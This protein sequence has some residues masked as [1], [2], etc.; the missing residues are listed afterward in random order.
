MYKSNNWI[1]SSEIKVKGKLHTR[2]L[3]IYVGYGDDRFFRLK[4]EDE[5]PRGNKAY[6]PQVD[7]NLYGI[8]GNFQPVGTCC[9]LL[10]ISYTNYQNKL[11]YLK[12]YLI[13][14]LIHYIIWFRW[15]LERTNLNMWYLFSAFGYSDEYNILQWPSGYRSFTN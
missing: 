5:E 15:I 1:G 12:S 9:M 6:K 3:D 7:F 4:L 8:K 2:N 13:I 10:M 14:A 11:F